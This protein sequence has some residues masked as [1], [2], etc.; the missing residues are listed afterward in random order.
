MARRPP[1]LSAVVI[2]VFAT[3]SLPLIAHHGI[4]TAYDVCRTVT[5]DGVLTA[6]EWRNPHVVLH[7]NVK[8]EDGNTLAW[9]VATP[10]PNVL[11][12][13]GLNDF[14]A[15]TGDHITAHVFVA[16]DGSRDAVTRDLI[17]PSGRTISVS[18]GT[19]GLGDAQATCSG[20]SPH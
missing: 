10:A 18:M 7:I 14:F 15:R 4:G 20:Q 16:K 5:L 19:G 11:N 8:G 6:L 3:T 1:S 9:S 17:L 13:Q 12:R 2:A